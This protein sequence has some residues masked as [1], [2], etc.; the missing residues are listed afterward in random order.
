MLRLGININ[1]VSAITLAEPKIVDVVFSVLLLWCILRSL[2]EVTVS[3]LFCKHV[4][5]ES[6]VCELLVFY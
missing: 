5:C 3:V 4:A 2:G 6:E 1:I